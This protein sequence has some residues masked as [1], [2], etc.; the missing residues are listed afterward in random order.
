MFILNL[1]NTNRKNTEEER[2][3]C[4]SLQFNEMITIEYL[5]TCKYDG[6]END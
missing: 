4:R 5:I 3:R 6:L 1:I 2:E